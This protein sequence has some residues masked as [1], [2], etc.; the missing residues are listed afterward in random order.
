MMPRLLKLGSQNLPFYAFRL[1]YFEALRL[2]CTSAKN[3]NGFTLVTYTS[4]PLLITSSLLFSLSVWD[5]L[6]IMEAYASCIFLLT[7]ELSFAIL[8]WFP[9]FLFLICRKFLK[10]KEVNKASD[11]GIS[12][13]FAVFVGLIGIVVG[14]L[15][16]LLS[17]L[18]STESAGSHWK[19]CFCFVLFFFFLKKGK[20]KKLNLGSNY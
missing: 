9:P 19:Q 20:K 6:W 5:W 15:L 14:W 17:S 10:I 12:I 7:I 8:E 11:P 1:V 4:L 2:W 16:N 18:P 13:I 3:M